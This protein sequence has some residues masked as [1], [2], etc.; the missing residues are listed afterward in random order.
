[1]DSIFE[2][3]TAPVDF[4]LSAD[5]TAQN[6]TGATVVAVVT[7]HVGNPVTV[8]NAVTIQVAASG[9]VRWVPVV[10]DLHARLSPY[11]FRFK[12]TDSGGDDEGFPNADAAY[13]LTVVAA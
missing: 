10:G 7:D 3:R 6:L 9:V 4:T 5:G 13:E 1:M 2:G 11:S 8:T 12:V